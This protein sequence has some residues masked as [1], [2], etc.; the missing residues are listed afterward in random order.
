M[1]FLASTLLTALV[2]TFLSKYIQGIS[3]DSLQAAVL[4]GVVLTVAH[5]VVK[6]VLVLLTL[7]ITLL[8]LGFFI[9][10]INAS[11]FLLAASFVPGFTVTNFTAALI[12]AFILSVAQAVVLKWL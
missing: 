4:A 6:P 9:L 10:V 8:T 11:I 2:V 3:V 5:T 7:P 1:K 12:G